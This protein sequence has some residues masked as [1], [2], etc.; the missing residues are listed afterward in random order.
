[1]VQKEAKVPL[2]LVK[3]EDEAAVVIV[4]EV[5]EGLTRLR[6]LKMK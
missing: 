5:A 4:A 1:M 2:S 3:E 6:I